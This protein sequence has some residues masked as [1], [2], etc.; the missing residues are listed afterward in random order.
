MGNIARMPSKV[1]KTSAR[2]GIGEW[3]GFQFKNLSADKRFQFAQIARKRSTKDAPSC[4]FVGDGTSA[5]T[6]RGGVCSLKLYHRQE[7]GSALPDGTTDGKLRIMCPK[8]FEQAGMVF[9]EVCKYMLN[10]DSFETSPQVRFLRRLTSDEEMPEEN[11]NEVV[12]DDPQK[13]EDVGNIDMVLVD[14]RGVH[15]GWCA[16]EIQAV[17][18]SGAKMSDLFAHIESYD[19]YG[20][21]FPDK[22]RRPDYRSSGPKRLMPQLQIKVPTL[23][24]WGKK[25]AVVVDIS[26]FWANVRG[27][28]EAD[29][30]SNADIVLFFVEF[31]ETHDTGKL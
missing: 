31:D 24:R 3:Y 4:P 2:F 28:K 16:L 15:V 12:D 17:Y 14:K 27:V 18:F 5:C 13:S 26:W 6:K 9:A 29:H 20:I 11:E 7:D 10:T 30:V 25:M 1:K 23:R 8:R 21:P 22:I 19:N